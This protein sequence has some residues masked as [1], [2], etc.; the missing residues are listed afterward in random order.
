MSPV[1]FHIENMNQGLIAVW[2]YQIRLARDC[3]E[4]PYKFFMEHPKSLDKSV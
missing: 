3:M 4:P 2:K 1:V